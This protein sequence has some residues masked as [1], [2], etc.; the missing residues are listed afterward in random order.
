M[1]F[2]A[3]PRWLGDA[4][5]PIQ[6][7]FGDASSGAEPPYA[8]HAPRVDPPIAPDAFKKALA[9]LASGVAIISYWDGSSPRGL[10]VSSITGLSLDP[11][12][13]LFCVRKEASSH[14]TLLRADHCGVTILAEDDEAEALRFSSS[15][16]SHERFD[17]RSWRLADDAPPTY[18]AGLS[19]ATCRIDQTTDAGTHNVFV[20]TAHAVRTA[21]GQPPGRLRQGVP[22][23]GDLAA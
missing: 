12:R 22:A 4:A 8:V 18:Q 23:P 6:V 14:D 20:V 7:P 21:P 2:D 13:F 11:P 19:V 10:L 9:R 5:W 16:L 15:S 1:A 17:P 3:D